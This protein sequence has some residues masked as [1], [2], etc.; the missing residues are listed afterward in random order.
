M[1]HTNAFD[2]VVNE[3]NT[4][5]AGSDVLSAA[6]IAHMPRNVERDWRN[7]IMGAFSARRLELSGGTGLAL[8]PPT[9]R[10]PHSLDRVLTHD[11]HNA[12]RRIVTIAMNGML[13]QHTDPTPARQLD[14]SATHL[15]LDS[16]ILY[17]KLNPD[18]RL[19]L[20]V[21]P[22]AGRDSLL[23]PRIA[24]RANKSDCAVSWAGSPGHLPIQAV[25]LANHS[26][27]SAFPI[28]F[29]VTLLLNDLYVSLRPCYCNPEAP[30]HIHLFK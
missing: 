11:Q 29:T 20:L 5:I 24:G 28:L 30:Y 1:L 16:L 19:L 3:I 22:L 25:S 14:W 10:T 27:L 6:G 17:L 4:P 9:P 15:H 8:G 23:S 18:T 13:R 12:V 2:P 26:P 7:V 21:E